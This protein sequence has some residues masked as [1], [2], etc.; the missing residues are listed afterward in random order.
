MS[1]SKETIILAHMFK[2]RHVQFWPALFRVAFLDAIY[3]EVMCVVYS[4]WQFK[5]MFFN[6]VE[7]RFASSVNLY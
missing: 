3:R 5:R 7:M 4:L 1:Q 2:S 6:G